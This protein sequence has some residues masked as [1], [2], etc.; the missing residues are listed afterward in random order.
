MS[1]RASSTTPCT[2]YGRTGPCGKPRYTGKCKVHRHRVS[3]RPCLLC[4]R[5]TASKT[6]HCTCSF[7]RIYLCQKMKCAED[8]AAA[9]AAELDR[10]I[11][12]MFA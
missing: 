11:L 5:E 1:S 9:Q 7:R 4:G 3:L 12:E 2:Y 6:Q 10:Q 8:A